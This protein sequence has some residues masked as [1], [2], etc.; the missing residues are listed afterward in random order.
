MGDCIPADCI[1]LESFNLVQC[2]ESSL[3]GEAA[4]VT[5]SI[6]SDPFM[7]SSSLLLHGAQCSALVIAVGLASQWG[8]IKANLVSEAQETPLQEKLASLAKKVN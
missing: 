2:D 1:L 5:K 3:T 7:L 8:Q 6:S 4:E